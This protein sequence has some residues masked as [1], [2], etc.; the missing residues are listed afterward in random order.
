VEPLLVKKLDH[1][2][3]S[4]YFAQH[5]YNIKTLLM[6][7]LLVMA[8]LITLNT[9]NIAYNDI[10]YKTNFSYKLLYQQQ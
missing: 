5:N 6:T 1:D 9:G 4:D 2:Q 3:H 7:T 10:T 8:I